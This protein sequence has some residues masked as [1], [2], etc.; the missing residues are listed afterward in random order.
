MRTA[1]KII[2]QASRAWN[3]H[4]APT[5]GAALA[6]FAMVSL[7][8]LVIITVTLAGM[9]YGKAA[10]QGQVVDQIE[11]LT[12]ETGA[13]AL[14]SLINSAWKSD[15]SL[16]ATLVGIGMLIFGA[17]GVFAQAQQTLN[18]IWGA[19]PMKGYGVVDFFRRRTLSIMASLSVGVILLSSLAITAWVAAAEEFVFAHLPRASGMDPMVDL[20][21][22]FLVISILF[23]LIY[24]LLPDTNI[25][26][27][28][29]W[30][31]AGITA[32][33]FLLGRYLIGVYLGRNAIAST[34]G[35]AG[36]FIAVLLWVY[37]SALIFF[38]GA[39]ITRAYSDIV[40]SH[41]I[42]AAPQV[43]YVS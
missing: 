36:S 41:K 21:V 34:Y 38:F 40:G 14:Q 17:S 2:C 35:A 1:W 3:D 18:I 28:D 20:A 19:R 5:H 27:R 37:Y 32:A 7:A 29:V 12:G 22:S 42:E 23:A 10:A 24:K 9:A 43:P 11:W 16:P 6:F 25:A 4:D 39:E 30:V 13:I 31:G 8:P 15:T 33:L 26:W